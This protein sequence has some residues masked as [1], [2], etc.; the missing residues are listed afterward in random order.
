ML[1]T[2]LKKSNDSELA[3]LEAPI[4]G[5]WVHAVNPNKKETAALMKLGIPL[6]FI[7]SSLDLSEQPRVDSEGKVKLLI[8]QVPEIFEDDL[9]TAT[10]GIIITDKY[11]VTVSKTQNKLLKTFMNN[12]K[13]FYTTKRTR[14][15]LQLFWTTVK[16][17]LSYLH[18]IDNMV[19]AVENKLSHSLGNDEIL[20]VLKVKKSLTF[21]KNASYGNQRVLDKIMTGKFLKLYDQDEGLLEDII[22]DN[23]QAIEMIG[24]YLDIT[25]NTMD[26]YASI[27]NN[28]MN[29]VI[30]FLTVVSISL[31]IPSLIA[32]FYGMNVPLPFDSNP[33]TFFG[34]MLFGMVLCAGSLLA[35]F[36]MKIL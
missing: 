2:M 22:I 18:N 9:E 32:S 36:K 19:D 27:V 8:L 29:I 16:S 33:L 26:A 28:N 31:A 7:R 15:L 13:G 30:K 17:Y 12:P 1:T 11:L 10:L 4:A 20:E 34:L 23:K 14:F 25:S 24:T 5:S 6:E 35:L 21:F 3:T